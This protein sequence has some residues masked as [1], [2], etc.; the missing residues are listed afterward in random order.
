M[1]GLKTEPD[2]FVFGDDAQGFRAQLLRI[3]I[4]M[5]PDKQDLVMQHLRGQQF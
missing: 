1:V 5:E 4:V 3:Q 2:D